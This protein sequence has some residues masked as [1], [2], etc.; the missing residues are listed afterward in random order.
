M[1]Y[2]RYD[3]GWMPARGYGRDFGGRRGPMH[4]HGHEV[5]NGRRYDAGMGGGYDRGWTEA[6]AY[7]REPGTMNGPGMFTPFG[8]DPML[9]WSGWDPLM[10]FV[11]YQDTP[12]AWSYGLAED[13]RRYEHDYYRGNVAHRYG[14]D[15]GRR[16]AYRPREH[17][18]APR[19][20]PLYGRG[21]DRAVRE[22]ARERGY[23]VGYTIQPRPG[24]RR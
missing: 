16:P 12:R 2:D 10:G 21:G 14:G 20:S 7:G 5:G 18:V 23:D 15:Y 6:M 17:H 19:Q 11:P 4:G 24:P 9:R 22:W 3:R 13:A 1:R 8:W